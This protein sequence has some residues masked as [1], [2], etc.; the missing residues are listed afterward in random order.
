LQEHGSVTALAVNDPKRLRELVPHT[1][2]EAP[3]ESGDFTPWN[4]KKGED[5]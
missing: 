4:W 1:Q 2:E 3:E 5:D